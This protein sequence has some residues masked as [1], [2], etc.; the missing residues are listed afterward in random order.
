V[1]AGAAVV[2]TATAGCSVLDSGSTLAVQNVSKAGR[3]PVEVTA[4]VRNVGEDHETAS[5]TVKVEQDGTL[6][7]KK[8]QTVEVPPQSNVTIRS[9]FLPLE[10]L[11]PSAY[12]VSAT[13]P[14]SD[15]TTASG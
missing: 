13:V 14:G 7:G 1:S 4:V 5:T 3:N 15:W 2:A 9:S 8:K 12:T 6:V 10:D 11:P